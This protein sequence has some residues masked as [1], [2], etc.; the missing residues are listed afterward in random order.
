MRGAES[1]SPLLGSCTLNC[2]ESTMPRDYNALRAKRIARFW[3]AV[4]KDGPTQPHMT[5]PCWEWTEGIA[6]GV[7]YGSARMQGVNG[8]H[9]IAYTLA[10]GPI[11]AGAHVCHACDNRLCVRPDHLW[12]GDRRANMADM[13]AKGR[14]MKGNNHYARTRPELVLRGE[15]SGS[16]KLT[17]QIVLDLRN[18]YAIQR[19]PIKHLAAELGIARATLRAALSGKTWSHVGGP[20]AELIEPLGRYSA[21]SV[22][23][24]QLQEQA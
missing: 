21:A 3:N 6:K 8:S 23:V 12:L 9:R 10:V 1:V 24:R 16:S 22:Q 19:R 5:T 11:P 2:L 4:N 14:Q 13:V 15:R 17:D 18:G 7:G 20:V